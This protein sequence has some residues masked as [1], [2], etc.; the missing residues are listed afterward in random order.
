MND[1]WTCALGLFKKVEFPRD[2]RLV[3]VKVSGLHGAGGKEGKG[4]K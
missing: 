4:G 1:I 2:V 3:G